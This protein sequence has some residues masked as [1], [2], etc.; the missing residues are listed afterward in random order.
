MYGPISKVQKLPFESIRSNI[1]TTDTE[2]ARQ[3]PIS[4]QEGVLNMLKLGSLMDAFRSSYIGVVHN[5]LVPG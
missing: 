5:G 2:V 1:S 4:R 3:Y